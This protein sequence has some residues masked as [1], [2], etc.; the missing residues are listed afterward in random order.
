MFNRKLPHG[1]ITKIITVIISHHSSVPLKLYIPYLRL[2]FG[3]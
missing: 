1:V 3:Q 2:K